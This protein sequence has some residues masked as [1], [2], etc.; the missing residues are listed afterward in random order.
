MGAREKLDLE[1]SEEFSFDTKP[2]VLMFRPT[3]YVIVPREKLQAWEE[4][5]RNEVGVVR[6]EAEKARNTSETICM[7]GGEG[8]GYDD[9]DWVEN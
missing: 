7:C 5:L 4:L 3:H 6:T 2:V 9:C 8:H 1:K